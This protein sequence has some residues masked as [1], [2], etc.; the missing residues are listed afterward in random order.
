MIWYRKAAEQGHP[1]TLNSIGLM[2]ENGQGVTK[3]KSKTLE[4]YKKA[5]KQGDSNA[6][7][8]VK[9][10]EREGCNVHGGKKQSLLDWI[11]G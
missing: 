11:F 9:K 3:D 2:F 1:I 8:A 7:N 6:V 10:L 5:A 4:W